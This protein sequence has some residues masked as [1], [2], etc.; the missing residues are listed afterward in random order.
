M[1]FG[2]TDYFIFC[3]MKVFSSAIQHAKFEHRL[4]DKIERDS[5]L[6]F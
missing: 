3:T 5:A 6:F 2:I 1:V 4:P